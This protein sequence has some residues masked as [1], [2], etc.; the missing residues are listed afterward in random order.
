MGRYPS[1]ADLLEV[2]AQITSLPNTIPS[3]APT[4]QFDPVNMCGPFTIR[5]YLDPKPQ[6]KITRRVQRQNGEA[7]SLEIGVE[8]QPSAMMGNTS[9]TTGVANSG[10]TY[11]WQYRVLQGINNYSATGVPWQDITEGVFSDNFRMSGTF[12]INGANSLVL[13]DS[14]EVHCITTFP[15]ATINTVIDPMCRA[16]NSAISG[17]VSV[18]PENANA[19]FIAQAPPNNDDLTLSMAK[20]VATTQSKPQTNTAPQTHAQSDEETPPLG[21]K[22]WQSHT[23]NL[24]TAPNPAETQVGLRFRLPSKATTTIEIV[25]A[26]QRTI[27]APMTAT[28]LERGE[29]ELSLSVGTL[30]SGT[31]TVR[32]KALLAN[33]ALLLE[34]RPL[35]I[36]R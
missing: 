16:M 36:V 18:R 5:Y 10:S 32:V 26:L 3:T 21:G 8:L 15:N 29:H 6:V 17:V 14:V 11:Q 19:N 2:T 27:L 28:A 12:N 13:N 23:V 1:C 9:G 25:D 22:A 7:F 4:D 33:G 35:I 31:Y 24:L 30:P 34:Q 20:N